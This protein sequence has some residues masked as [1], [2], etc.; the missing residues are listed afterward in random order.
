MDEILSV[1]DA[2][3]QEKSLDRMMELMSGG[4]TVL[5]VSH[6]IRQVRDMCDQVLWLDHGQIRGWGPAGEICRRY[7]ESLGMVSKEAAE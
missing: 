3:F 1:G 7:E 2:G 5:F 4:T 6:D